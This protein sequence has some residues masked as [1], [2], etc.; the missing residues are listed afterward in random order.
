MPSIPCGR[1]TSACIRPALGLKIEVTQRALIE[2]TFEVTF[3]P[4]IW[5][6]VKGVLI[7]KIHRTWNNLQRKA[8]GV[9]LYAFIRVLGFI[10][11]LGVQ[12]EDLGHVRPFRPENL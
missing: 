6:W 11:V 4:L 12:F 5:T 1:A 9:P 7:Q 3:E 10:D 2:D 8:R